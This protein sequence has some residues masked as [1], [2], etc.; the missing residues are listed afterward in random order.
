MVV[1]TR[2]AECWLDAKLFLD[3]YPRCGIKGPHWPIIQHSMFLHATREGQKE[4]E[5]MICWGHWQNL[6]RQD[7]KES[8]SAA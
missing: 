2:E 4:A 3:E 8:L 6:P 7:P 1:S 5:Q